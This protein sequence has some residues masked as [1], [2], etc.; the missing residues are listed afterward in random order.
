MKNNGRKYKPYSAYKSSGVEWIGGIPEGW[1]VRGL[2]YIAFLKSGENITSENINEIDDYPVFGGN[3]LRGYFPSFSHDGNFIL[4]RRQGA[5]CG[6]INYAEGKFWASEHAV[7]LTPIINY[8]AFWLGEL[9]R[10]MNLNQYSVSAAQPGL[11]VDKIKNLLIPLPPL[12]EQRAIA[13][14]PDLE[15]ARIDTLI[16]K[17]ERQIELLN[18]YKQSLITSAVTGKIDVR[19]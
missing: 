12:T 18:E 3:G 10:V 2:K 14:F 17:I 13:D 15:T 1:D 16:E 4:I 6:N 11:S 9:L 7:V 5:L 8:S 19:G